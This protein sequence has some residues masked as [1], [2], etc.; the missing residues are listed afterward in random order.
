MRATAALT[1]VHPDALNAWLSL[2]DALDRSP[3]TAKRPSASNAPTSGA[4][5]RPSLPRED[6]AE[7]C[8]FCPVRNACE[9]SPTPTA[10]RPASGAGTDCTPIPRTRKAA[11]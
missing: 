11:A 5:T 10:N 6:A 4:P 7:A 3:T 9:P 2:D 1:G 8:D